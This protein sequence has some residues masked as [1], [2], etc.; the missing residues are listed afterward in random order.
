MDGEDNELERLNPFHQRSLSSR[1]DYNIN[2]E[3]GESSPVTSLTSPQHIMDDVLPPMFASLPS[4]SSQPLLVRSPRSETTF[5]ELSSAER[6]SIEEEVE[7]MVRDRLET[8]RE[9]SESN[10][11]ETMRLRTTSA[12]VPSSSPSKMSR[13][14]LS[15]RLVKESIKKHYA[16]SADLIDTSDFRPSSMRID[17]LDA[18]ADDER[19]ASGQITTEDQKLIHNILPNS[20]VLGM[21]DS[22]VLEYPTPK[23]EEGESP[24]TANKDITN[25]PRQVSTAKPPTRRNAKLTTMLEMKNI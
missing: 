23:G 9:R 7:M 5:R 12:P 20:D 21:L 10:S 15:S 24:N 22:V 13:I 18:E 25:R 11:S 3:D 19:K 8:K 6:K 14:R 1:R 16:N 4:S 2:V 17:S